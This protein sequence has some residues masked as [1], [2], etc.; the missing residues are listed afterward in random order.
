METTVTERLQIAVCGAGQCDKDT[1]AKAE[2]VGRLIAQNGAILLCG[3]LGGVMEA[4]CKGALDAGGITVGILPTLERES[5]NPYVGIAIA[6]GA[7]HARNL[8]IVASADAII[9]IGGE[10]GTLSEIALALK[11]GKPVIGL[12]TW[13]CRR[14]ALA[15]GILKASNPQEAVAMALEA[16]GHTNLHA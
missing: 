15:T 9:A 13:E 1:A 8:Y 11:L 5:A 3:G 2:E 16:P 10:Y 4:A 14:G 7:S 6:T 12:D